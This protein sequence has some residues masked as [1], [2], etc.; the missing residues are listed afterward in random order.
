MTKFPQ[1]SRTKCYFCTAQEWF[2]SDGSKS[3]NSRRKGHKELDAVAACQGNFAQSQCQ[4]GQ[5]SYKAS[6]SIWVTCRFKA[7]PPPGT[8]TLY[9]FYVVIRAVYRRLCPA[10]NVDLPWHGGGH[11]HG[12]CQVNLHKINISRGNHCPIQKQ[13][14]A[15]KGGRLS[16]SSDLRQSLPFRPQRFLQVQTPLFGFKAFGPVTAFCP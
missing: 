6:W 13:L 11:G 16:Q 4:S 2:K 7:H 1:N 9:S 5:N 14:R 3:F 15:S 10:K 8:S 12:F